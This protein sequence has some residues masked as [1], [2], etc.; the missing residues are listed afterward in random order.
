M[1]NKYENGFEFGWQQRRACDADSIK[2]KILQACGVTSETQWW[3]LRLGKQEL[4]GS[5]ISAIE[6]IFAEYGITE[7]WGTAETEVSK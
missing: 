7:V 2:A 1:R 4:K 3:A 5:Q 6:Q